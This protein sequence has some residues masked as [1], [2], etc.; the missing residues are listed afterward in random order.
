MTPAR[1]LVVEDER[2]AAE[3]ICHS[4]RGLGYDVVGTAASG[5]EAIRRAAEALPD[6]VL[7]DIVLRGDVDGVRTAEN[8]KAHLDIPV[9]YLSAHSDESTLR[10]AKITEP[11]G[12]IL[13]P[14]EPRELH[15]NIEIALYK[16]HMEKK[17]K[18]GEETLRASLE[19][20]EAQAARTEAIIAA[21]GDGISIQNTDFKILYQNQIHK[22]FV[23]DHI[24]EYC[25]KA[26]ECRENVCEGCPLAMAFRDGKIHTVERSNPTGTLCVEITASPIRDATGKIIAG[27]EIARDV[28]KRKHDQEALRESEERYRNLFENA[29]DM[30]QSIDPEGRFIFVN[31][32]WLK[33]LGYTPEDLQRLTIFD[34]VHPD[35]VPHCAEILRKVLSGEAADNVEAT[36]ISKDGRPVHVEGNVNARCAG[37]KAIATQ[38]IFRDV[39]ERKRAEAERARLEAQLLHVQKMEAI[40]TLTGGIAHEFNNIMTVVIG[41]SEFL[42]EGMESDNPLRTYVNLIQASAIRATHLTQSLLAYS[43][44]QAI[45]PK[46]VKLSEA[47]RNVGRLLARLIGENIQLEIGTTDDEISI[48]ADAGQ[49]EQVLINLATNARDAMPNGGALTIRTARTMLDDS[50]VKTHAYVKPGHYAE[51]SV[52]DTGIGMDDKTKQR[53]FEPFFTTKEM[54]KGTGLGLAMVYGIIKQ[55]GG[56]IDVFSEPGKG[57]TFKIYLPLIASELEEPEF[58][59]PDPVRTGSETVLVA[60]DDAAV[61]KLTQEVLEKAGYRV[62]VAGDGEEAIL[63]FL[64]NKD[65]IDLLVL[66][67]I[68]PGKNGKEAYREIRKLKPDQ[69]VMFLSGYT[70]DLISKDGGLAE[71][72]TFIPKPASPREL[73]KKVRSLLDG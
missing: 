72:S 40:G 43:R 41:Y 10:R 17:L 22:G 26:Y 53:I 14:F 63:K 55:H 7:M 46:P 47:V 19:K 12:Y 18:D 44:K 65:E 29:H 73:L 36:F 27:I 67:V 23:G 3:E 61:R 5:E 70:T 32:S 54:G 62:I 8:I 34:I 21:I 38:G 50:F 20:A 71:G 35:C 31:S 4:L 30:I 68:M 37:G 51:L 52:K 58:P 6:L 48:M 39:T 25:Y 24:G 15:I 11:Y 33:T 69:K 42:Q 64:A 57:T 66:D 59:R 60:E 1:I 28:T 16:H 2:L 9:V 49:M 45:N 13:K 56:Y